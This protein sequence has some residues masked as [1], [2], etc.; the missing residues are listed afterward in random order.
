MRLKV[1]VR[2]RVYEYQSKGEKEEDEEA[3]EGDHGS[4]GRRGRR[5]GREEGQLTRPGVDHGVL[6]QLGES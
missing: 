2:T 6:T 4:R 3:G 1:L 5:R